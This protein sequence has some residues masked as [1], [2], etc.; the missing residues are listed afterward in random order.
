MNYQ[1]VVTVETQEQADA[2]VE[3]LND[4]EGEMLCFPFNVQVNYVK[5]D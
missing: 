1:V 3:V 5:G 4:A 2:V